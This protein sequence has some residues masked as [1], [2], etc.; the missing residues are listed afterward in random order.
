MR[1]AD[2]LWTNGGNATT[3]P[4]VMSAPVRLQCTNAS[5][6]GLLIQYGASAPNGQA[7]IQVLDTDGTPL[8]QI[9]KTATGGNVT[10]TGIKVGAVALSYTA[11]PANFDGTQNPPCLSLPDGT[12]GRNYAPTAT[13]FTNFWS[14]TGA[15]S[16]S[17]VGLANVGDIYYRRDTPGVA[18]QNVYICT[19]AGAPGTWSGIA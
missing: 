17:T 16:A 3:T 10:F 18:N 2:D 12:Q 6:T 8:M 5:G 9:P 1:G 14:G 15:P 11:P 19:V 4:G 13:N 7:A